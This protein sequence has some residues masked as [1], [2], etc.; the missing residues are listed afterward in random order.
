MGGQGSL[1]HV[2]SEGWPV[3]L[4]PT[5]KPLLLKLLKTLILV[6][7]ERCQNTQ[8]TQFVADGATE[9][10]TSQ[11]A[12]A[13]PCPPSTNNHIFFY[14]TWM[15]RC[16]CATYLENT[17]HRDALCKKASQLRQCDALGN[18]LLGNLQS[19]HPW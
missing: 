17:L 16:V 3:W 10:Q 5:D 7:I 6:L 8:C 13:D 4:D 18:V 9:Q 12:H 19:C 14:I 2:R 11:G 1:M 15:A